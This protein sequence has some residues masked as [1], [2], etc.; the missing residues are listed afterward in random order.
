MNATHVLWTGPAA[1]MTL[2]TVSTLLVAWTGK[3]DR[4]IP[5]IISLHLMLMMLNPKDDY[6]YQRPSLLAGLT[7]LLLSALPGFSILLFA[8]NLSLLAIW[9]YVAIKEKA[10]KRKSVST[11]A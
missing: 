3:L 5:A 4:R 7:F 9:A 10:K 1:L 11:P 2:W 8:G 6:L